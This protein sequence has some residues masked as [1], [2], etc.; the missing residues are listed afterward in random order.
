M[1]FYVSERK[2][3]WNVNTS[4]KKSLTHKNQAFKERQRHTLPH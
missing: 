2:F 1:I 3:P 4:H